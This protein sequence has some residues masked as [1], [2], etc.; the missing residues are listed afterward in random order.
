MFIC[1]LHTTELPLLLGVLP[2]VL[3]LGPGRTSMGCPETPE[4][5]LSRYI[6]AFGLSGG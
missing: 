5:I 6:V 4:A 2:L 1:H 3:F